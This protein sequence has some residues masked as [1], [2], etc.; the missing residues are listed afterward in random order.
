MATSII[1]F[2]VDDE[3][4]QEAIAVYDRIGIDLST[5]I[6]MFLKRSVAENGIPFPTKFPKQLTKS[7]VNAL[8]GK[9]NAAAENAGVSDMQ[10]DEINAEIS[11]ARKERKERT[12][13]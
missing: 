10:L 7:E 3:L 6:R 11:A 2:R 4:K 8:L 13:E 12:D 9:F 5:A 1:Q